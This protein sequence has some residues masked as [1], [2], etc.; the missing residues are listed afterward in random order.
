[1]SVID[2]CVLT[3][4][5]HGHRNY[6]YVFMEMFR[7]QVY[8]AWQQTNIMRQNIETAGHTMKNQWNNLKIKNSEYIENIIFLIFKFYSVSFLIMPHILP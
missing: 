3:S 7:M 4:A 2:L 1:M 8:I 6:I 5:I